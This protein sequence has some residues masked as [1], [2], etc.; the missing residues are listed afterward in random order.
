MRDL[1]PVI[2][3]T[4]L[5]RSGKVLLLRRARTGYLDGWYALPGGHLRRGESVAEC[6]IRE[7]LEETGI[8]IDARVLRSAAVMPYRTTDQQGVNFIMTCEE[9]SGEPKLAEPDRFDDLGWWS[10]GALP[11]MTAPYIPRAVALARSAEWFFEF[12]SS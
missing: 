5:F 1:F 3:H 8:R 9:F 12:R 10:E 11:P 2:V 7:C 6:A 4:L